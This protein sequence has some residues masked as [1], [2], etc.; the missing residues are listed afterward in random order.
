[1]VYIYILE[2]AENKYY[3]GKSNNNSIRINEYTDF[4]TNAN[5][6]F[7]KYKP[8]KISLIIP[9]CDEF[10]EDKYTIKYMRKYGIDNVRGGS[11]V[12]VNLDD[13]HIRTIKRMICSGSNACYN[14]GSTSHYVKECPNMDDFIKIYKCYEC[15]KPF[16]T[17]ESLSYHKAYCN[18][19]IKCYK[20]GQYGHM[21]N[22][23][24]DILTK[25]KQGFF[26][27]TSMFD[28]VWIGDN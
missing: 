25:I 9:N 6:W 20:C 13:E 7:V 18:K 26:F 19:N 4:F 3:I 24:P 11:F 21:S 10:D 1:M 14:C 22:N 16:D 17:I 5:D 12:K 15:D 23:C 28:S 27:V 8:T 2:L